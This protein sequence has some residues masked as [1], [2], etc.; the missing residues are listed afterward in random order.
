MT[1]QTMLI[2]KESGHIGTL[3]LNRPEQLNA[4]STTVAVEFVKA[5][6][7]LEADPEVRVIILKGSGKAFSAGIDISEFTGK[8]ACEYKSWVEQMERSLQ[9]MM[10]IGK[11]VIAQVH[12]VAAAN[13]AGLVA[14]SDLAVAS[15]DA[16]I[17]FTAV[18][19]GLFCLGPAVPLN[20]MVTRKRA[21]ELLYFGD[22]IPA[23]KAYEFGLVNQVVPRDQL[24]EKTREYALKLAE[25]SPLAVQISKK[26]L[27]STM[28]M[29]LHQAFDHMNE[30]F[31]RLCT[32]EDAHEG[33]Q[34]FLEKR[35][36]QWRER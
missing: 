19:V 27:N 20:R 22:L 25:K 33:V 13:G 21:M 23:S 9:C 5:L 30:A 29:E 28:D 4:F 7:E 35:K 16:R 10:S 1:Y 31:A 24:E 12:G 3:T 14:A 17:G 36:P 26:A 34:A 32:T 8:S 11:P 15:D 18:N 6:M 2:G